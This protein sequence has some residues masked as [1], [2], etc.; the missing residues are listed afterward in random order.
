[1][2]KSWINVMR[3]VAVTALM[4]GGIVGM[5]SAAQAAPTNCDQHAISNGY[6]VYCGKGSG[7]YRA[8]ITCWYNHGTQSRDRFGPWRTAGG[9]PSQVSCLTSEELGGYRTEK[10]G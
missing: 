4:A 5:G 3:T 7:Q 9:L 6:Y 10:K 1:M 8:A 2:T